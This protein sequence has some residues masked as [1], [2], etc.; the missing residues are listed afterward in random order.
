MARNLLWT[1]AFEEAYNF[2]ERMLK[3]FPNDI[4]LKRIR[5][6]ALVDGY[7]INHINK[8]GYKIIEKSSLDFFESIV[9]DEENRTASDIKFL[10]RYYMW[11]SDD[12]PK[13][14]QQAFDLFEW[15]KKLYPN[16]WMFDFHIA[17]YYNQFGM[18]GQ[19]LPYIQ[20]AIRK[21]PWREIAYDDCGRIYSNL[22][23][24]AKAQEMQ[25]KAKEI[26]TIKDKL[27]AEAKRV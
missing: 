5:A 23:D 7:V 9:N 20:E 19:A 13:L 4:S 6:E 14:R 22:G 18:P 2:T 25:N 8:D 21:A 16:E 12:D 3:T 26:K 10:A 24:I 27:Y 1:S 17:A 15:G 11:M